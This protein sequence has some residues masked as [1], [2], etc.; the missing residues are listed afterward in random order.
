MGISIFNVFGNEPEGNYL[1]PSRDP[2]AVSGST[3]VKNNLATNGTAREKNVLDEL[4]HGNLPD[5]LRDLAPV[6]V[7]D[8]ANTITYL[9]SLDYLSIGNDQD[10]CR[11][12]MSPLTAQKIADKFDCTLPTRKMVNDIWKNAP[13]KLVYETTT[14]DIKMLSTGRY[15]EHNAMINKKLGSPV[16]QT[17]VAGHKKDVV[18]TNKLAPKNASKRVAIYGWFRANG[19]VIQDLNPTDHDDMY[20]DYSHGIRL[21]ANDVMVNGLPM[22]IQDV[23]SDPKLCG[24]LSDE[25]VLKFLR[26]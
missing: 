19:T 13:T 16:S 4:I 22:R 12:P 14:P 11:M 8:G 2:G 7:T 17:I 9:V 23:F 26:Y 6:V 24:L 3:F 5:Y 15:G 18:L 20:A 25:G 10:F 1:F 21:I